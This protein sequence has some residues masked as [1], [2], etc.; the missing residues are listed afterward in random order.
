MNY[1]WHGGGW[2]SGMN[3]FGFPWGGILMAILLVGLVA[4][5]VVLLVRTGR[6]R[7]GEG[8][9]SSKNGIEILIER[10]AR[11][12]IDAATFKSMKAELSER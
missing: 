7:I 8:D 10:F 2:E 4:L 5:V 9:G 11:G 3:A 12:E 6:T 1:G